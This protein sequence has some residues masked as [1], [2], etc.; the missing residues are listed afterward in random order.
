MVASKDAAGN[1]K[2]VTARSTLAALA[3]SRLS[4]RSRSFVAYSGSRSALFE[5]YHLKNSLN[6]PGRHRV[7]VKLPSQLFNGAE[8]LFY[9]ARKPVGGRLAADG[10]F[11]ACCF[12]RFSLALR[13]G[14][15][16][17]EQGAGEDDDAGGEEGAVE[18]D[19]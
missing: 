18:A 12:H 16:E 17:E 14:D 9:G 19:H 7:A 3:G 5:L 4:Q 2:S 10:V 1:P 6:F 13:G 11:I 15:A 8:A